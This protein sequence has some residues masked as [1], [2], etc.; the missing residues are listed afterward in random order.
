[1]AEISGKGGAMT[2]VDNQSPIRLFISLK[3]VDVLTLVVGLFIFGSIYV[4][5]EDILSSKFQRLEN[6]ALVAEANVEGVLR[7]LSVGMRGLASDQEAGMTLPPALISRRQLAFLNDFAEVRTITATDKSGQVIAAESIQ[8]PDDLKAIRAFNVSAREYFQFHLKAG[9]A[10]FDR[11][12][13]SRPFIGV[14]KRWIVVASRAIRGKKGEFLGVVVAT[15][16]P[17]LFEPILQNIMNNSRVDAVAIHNRDGDILYRLPD[18]DQ[19]IGKNIAKGDAFQKYLQAEGN[20]TRYTGRVA[21]DGSQRILVYA[22]VSNSD[23][24]VGVSENYENVVSSWCPVAIGKVIFFCIF[25]AVAVAFRKQLKRRQDAI[26]ALAESEAKFRQLA[27]ELEQRVEQRTEQLVVAREQA[28][29]ASVAKSA[30]LANMSHEIRTPMN[31]VLGMANLL[32]RTELTPT[33][34]DFVD[35]ISTSG[36]HLVAIINDIL[37]LSKIEAGRFEL[38]D[39]PL[40]IHLLCNNVIRMLSERARGK[41]VLLDAETIAMPYKLRG[42]PTRVQ[43]A[44]LNYASNAIKFTESGRVSLRV[45]HEAESGSDLTLRFEVEDTGIGIDPEALN[46]LFNAFEQADNSTTRRYGGTGLGLAITKKLAELMDGQVGVSSTV[47]EGSTFWFTARFRKDGLATQ[48]VQ[49][50]DSLSVDLLI[51]SRHAGKRILLVEDEPVNREIAEML[52]QDVGLAVDLAENG[53]QAVE[54]AKSTT[55]DLIL[56]DMQ[57]PVLDGVSAT[58]QIRLLSSCARP[59]ILALTANAFAD[60]RGRCMAAGMNDFIAKPFDPDVLYRT[61]LHWLDKR[62]AE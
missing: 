55:Y 48:D 36:K 19:Y 30:F 61:L 8:T 16:K 57:M 50:A 52:L 54:K 7:G 2:V 25:F 27:E 56:M 3:S 33:Q 13:L 31:G 44:L 5:Y 43:Q 32:Q 51:Q 26:S 35:K 14:S 53:Q 60:D 42:D 59:P 9:A 15:L 18:A 34:H 20:I 40:D 28:E 45:R 49:V 12:Y 22:R 37:D 47:G 58:G 4:D 6:Q 38:E 21:T 24:D 46:R 17:T 10:D 39:E 29:A 41:G 1:V 11:L 23:L 62:P